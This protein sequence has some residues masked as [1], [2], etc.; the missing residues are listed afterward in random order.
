MLQGAA[1]FD[2]QEFY[3]NVDASKPCTLRY[4]GCFT[5][6]GVDEQFAMYWVSEHKVLLFCSLLSGLMS[7]C[8]FRAGGSYVYTKPL[9]ELLQ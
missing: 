7:T 1:P 5:D 2:G 3:R 8:C 6:G 4:H 9:G